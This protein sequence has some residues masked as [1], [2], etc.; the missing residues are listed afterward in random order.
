MRLGKIYG[1]TASRVSVKL[2]DIVIIIGIAAMAVLIPY[3]SAKG[4]F[5]VSFDS[6]GGTA[7]EAQRVRYGDAIEMP[8]APTRED[9]T[10]E[11]WYYDKDGKR[12]VDFDTAT[13]ER[14]TTLYAKWIE[15]E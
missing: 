11:G 8:E 14:S 15:K 5:T 2:L 13:A 9:Y 7:V 12:A 6:L 4:G 1:K 10:F 3:L